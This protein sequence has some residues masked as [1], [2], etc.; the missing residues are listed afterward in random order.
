MLWAWKNTTVPQFRRHI[1]IRLQE[2]K[3]IMNPSG[4]QASLNS[5]EGTPPS[6]PVQVEGV[7][8]TETC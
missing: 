7:S 8:G 1:R 5:Y 3:K 6:P 4:W 2:V